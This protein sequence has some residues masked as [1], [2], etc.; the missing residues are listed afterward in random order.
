MYMNAAPHVPNIRTMCSEVSHLWGSSS[1][2]IKVL[3]HLIYNI[4]Y[5]YI[6]RKNFSLEYRLSNYTDILII[7]WCNCLCIRVVG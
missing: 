4:R 7:D 5:S 3:R 2:I 6:I 1:I